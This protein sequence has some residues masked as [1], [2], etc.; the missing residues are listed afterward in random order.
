MASLAE[1]SALL[2]E[3]DALAAAGRHRDVLERL[4]R[5]PAPV[6]EGRTRFALLAAETHGRLGDLVAGARWAAQALELA[7]ARSERH[8][9]M[10]ARNYQGAIGLRRAA[11][12][13]AEQHFAAALEL[14]RELDDHATQA[15]CLNNLAILY[16]M[17]GDP[18]SALVSYRRAVTEYEHVGMTRGIAETQHNIGISLRDLGDLRGALRAAEEAVRLAGEAGDER[19]ATLAETGR[20]EYHLRLGDPA[21]AAAELDRAA[22]RYDRIGFTAGL[23]EVRRLQAAVAQARGS[24]DEAERLLR[25]AG[26]LATS[27][28]LG[29]VLADVRRDLTALGRSADSF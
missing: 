16:N 11:V 29:E 15:R 2:R 24:V 8:A 18:R 28:G 25:E 26:R 14:A 13:E 17:G 21:L 27:H 3:L 19:L 1:E 22:A 7:R 9:E 5:V 23:A 10:R 6:L 20:A 4:T 12:D